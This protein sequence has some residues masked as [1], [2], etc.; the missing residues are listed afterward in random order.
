M[1]EK[2]TYVLNRIDSRLLAEL[3]LF[4]RDY[5]GS[6][7]ACLSF[8]Y[9]IL[10]NEP[11]SCE[12]N[13]DVPDSVFIPR[14]MMNS[15][16]RLVS[17]ARDMEQIRRGKDVFKIVYLVTCAETLQKLAGS[18]DSKRDMLFDF[19]E[20]NTNAEDK[21][22]IATHF[23]LKD[24]LGENENPDSFIQFIG[25]INELRNCATH[26]GDFWE[27]YFNNTCDK[28]PLQVSLELNLSTFSPNNKTPH[29]FCTT[30]SYREFEDVFIRTCISFIA[31]FVSTKEPL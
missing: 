23:Q 4:Y 20:Q 29:T 2:L 10:E 6:D 24:D 8:I 31:N 9:A 30:L 27:F 21:N 11:L 17:A 13:T 19:F 3:W 1:S 14:R 18:K 28:W 7:D 26:E 12:F 22:F 25:V 15:C 16:M 5:F